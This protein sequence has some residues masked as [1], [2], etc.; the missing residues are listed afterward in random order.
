MA[1][2]RAVRWIVPRVTF[3]GVAA[4]VLFGAFLLVGMPLLL[5]VSRA[6]AIPDP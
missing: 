3:A 6:D 5:S 4:V 2:R 1:A